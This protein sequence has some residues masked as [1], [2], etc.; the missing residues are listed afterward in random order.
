MRGQIAVGL[1]VV[2]ALVANAGCTRTIADRG[3]GWWRVT[4]EH[5]RLST[6]L[7]RERAVTAGWALEDLH[8][9]VL[10]S[11]P[12]CDVADRVEPIEVTMIARQDEYAAIARHGDAMFRSSQPGFVALPSML[13]TRPGT[14][15]N[16][17]YVHWLV[18]RLVAACH[19]SAPPWVQEGLARYFET[20]EVEGDELIVGISA[21]DIAGGDAITTVFRAGRVIVPRVPVDLV[22]QP[23]ALA[24]MAEPDFYQD[25]NDA[26]AASAWLLVHLLELGPSADLRERFDRYLG[27]IDAQP[28]QLLYFEASFPTSEIEEAALAYVRS[29]RRERRV[30]Y[31][32][33]AHADPPAVPLPAPEAHLLLASIAGRRSSAAAD[34]RAHLALAAGDAATE[35]RARL[36][37][38]QLGLYDTTQSKSA[39]LDALAT[40]HPD[41]L[42]VLS[43]CAQRELS[44]GRPTN[45]GRRLLSVMATRAD[46]APIDDV[47]A[48][49][50]ASQAQ[51]LDV[52]ERLAR[53]AIEHASSDPLAHTVLSQLLAGRGEREGAGREDRIAWILSGH[54][55]PHW[56]WGADAPRIAG[57]VDAR[58]SAPIGPPPPFV[59]DATPTRCDLDRPVYDAVAIG[60]EVV[61]GRHSPWT[62]SDDPIVASNWVS[63]MNAFVGQ[64]AHVTDFPTLDAAGCVVVRVDVDGGTWMWRTRDMRA[65]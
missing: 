31:H 23:S 52:A 1:H 17:P 50:L 45:E 28:N 10:A 51:Q 21:F 48:A 61:L 25:P 27:D 32:P 5:V 60:T 46:L 55:R 44:R 39:Y 56:L 30:P 65:P 29:S 40:A 19:P 26:H 59:R 63:E 49:L 38:L 41:D 42:F 24:A 36:L 64:H 54:G 15:A 22:A 53:T 13:V 20:L 2:A 33:A 8:R 12:P 7:D 14:Y 3:T 11:F 43:A 34:A 6:D 18:H 58:L 47:R 57:A 37:A 9:A 62:E 4:S 16:G 35:V